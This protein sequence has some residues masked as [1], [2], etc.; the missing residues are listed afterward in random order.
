MAI[1]VADELEMV[2]V[3]DATDNAAGSSYKIRAERLLAQLVDEQAAIERNPPKLTAEAL[4][5]GREAMANAIAA[6]R[7]TV[8]AIRAAIA[9]G[10]DGDERGDDAEPTDA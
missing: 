4:T 1:D 5:E 9:C 7:R 10:P 2:D 8:E 3:S 6:A